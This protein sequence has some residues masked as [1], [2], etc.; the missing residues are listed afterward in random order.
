MDRH[1]PVEMISGQVFKPGILSDNDPGVVDQDTWIPKHS[2]GL[3][4]GVFACLQI[5]DVRDTPTR[6]AA[7]PLSYGLSCYARPIFRHVDAK[8][9]KLPSDFTA[10]V[11]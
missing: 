4:Q 7:S 1:H 10:S 5:P 8:V 6:I 2:T 3:V 9:P 11:S